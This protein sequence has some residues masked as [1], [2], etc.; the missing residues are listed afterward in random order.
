MSHWEQNGN[1]PRLMVPDSQSQLTNTDRYN[2]SLYLFD[3]TYLQ[4]MLPHSS[5]HWAENNYLS[6]KSL[7]SHQHK[8]NNMH[9]SASTVSI[10]PLNSGTPNAVR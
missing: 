3:Y 8:V 2:A 9:L 4:K 10:L 1:T 5:V 6:D 7:S